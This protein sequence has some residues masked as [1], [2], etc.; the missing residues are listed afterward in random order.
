LR[1]AIFLA[2]LGLVIA[3]GAMLVLNRSSDHAEPEAPSPVPEPASSEPA[4]VTPG[5]EVRP[6]PMPPAA[7]S[8]PPAPV[9]SA[10]K[11][12]RKLEPQLRAQRPKPAPATEDDVLNQRK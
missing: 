3:G 11:R 10:S 4:A 9:A 12:P 6:L 8:A 1:P 5:P 7:S 2:A